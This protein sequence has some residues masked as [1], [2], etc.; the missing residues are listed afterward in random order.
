MSKPKV[1]IV[2][3]SDSDLSVMQET[4][5]IL[6]SFKIEYEMTICSFHRAPARTIEYAQRVETRGL[7]VIICGAGGAA[8]LAGSIAAQTN[9]PIIGVP[10]G[11]P[12]L[13]GVDSLYS[14]LQMPGGVPVA[15]M[16]IGVPGARNAAVL[17]AQILAIKYPEIKERLKRYKKELVKELEE[18]AA[19][20]ERLGHRRY[21]KGR[22]SQKS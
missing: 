16:A 17:A 20:L 19:A 2:M 9:L 6:E 10:I 21:L 14:T 4:A 11:T 5:R 18:E 3:G 8:H 1:G 15:T 22:Q 7:E 13:S 12:A